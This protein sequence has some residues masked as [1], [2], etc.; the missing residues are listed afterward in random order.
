MSLIF[1][2]VKGA[3]KNPFCRALLSTTHDPVYKFGGHRI[4]IF[5]I[6]QY[7]LFLDFSFSGHKYSFFLFMN[8]FGREAELFGFF[9]SVF[10]AALFTVLDAYGVQ[11]ATDDVIPDSRTVFYPSSS[12]EKNG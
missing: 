5:W 4:V 11:G 9:G 10:G 7:F 2:D 6:R 3:I 8:G 12:N 1:D